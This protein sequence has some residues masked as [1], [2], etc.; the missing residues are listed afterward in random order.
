METLPGLFQQI[1]SISSLVYNIYSYEAVWKLKL[2]PQG[3]V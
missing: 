3:I 2:F 1:Q